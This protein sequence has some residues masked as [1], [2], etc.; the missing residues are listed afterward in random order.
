MAIGK[1]N[2]G[3]R[4]RQDLS[5][6]QF[7]V[8]TVISEHK[9]ENRRTY[10]LCRCICGLER[11]VRSDHLDRFMLQYDH[12]TCTPF[13]RHGLSQTRAYKVHTGMMARCYNETN[14]NFPWYGGIGHYVCKRWR[15][16]V[17]SFVEDMGQPPTDKHQLDRIDTLK[18]YT[19]GHCEE[20]KERSEPAN[21]RW[22]TKAVQV[23]NAKNNIWVTHEGETL[24]LKDWARRFGIAYLT[25]YR[26]FVTYGWS[27]E[28]AVSKP[29]RQLRR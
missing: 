21:C 7:G 24:I 18:H 22:A 4:K 25:L 5:G 15:E 9:R 8:L 11:I 17:E 1:G 3:P 19:C 2:W 26:R 6:K 16:S 10:W 20:C 23:R 12:C 14:D 28:K 13:Q 27:F 29:L